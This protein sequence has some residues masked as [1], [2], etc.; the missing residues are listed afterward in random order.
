MA[1]KLSKL[2]RVTLGSASAELIGCDFEI[3]PQN[4]ELF[5]LANLSRR[6][7]LE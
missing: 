2:F 7:Y 6:T 4:R 5:Y 3:G 1:R